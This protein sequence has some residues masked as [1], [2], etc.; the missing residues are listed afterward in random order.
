MLCVYIA[1]DAHTCHVIGSTFRYTYSPCIYNTEVWFSITMSLVPILTSVH[2]TFST[3]WSWCCSIFKKSSMSLHMYSFWSFSKHVFTIMLLLC[4]RLT[5]ALP[6]NFMT[7]TF[8]TQN[9]HHCSCWY[10]VHEPTQQSWVWTWWTNCQK[11]TWRVFATLVPSSW[12]GHAAATVSQLFLSDHQRLLSYFFN[13]ETL[14]EG[15][16]KLLALLALAG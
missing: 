6:Y 11:W 13:G 8:V 2:N 16:Q 9:L 12:V 1:Q 10:W 3:R 15:M 7:L 5:T 14:R 4:M